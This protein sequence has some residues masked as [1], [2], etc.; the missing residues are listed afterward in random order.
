[1]KSSI[2]EG[3]LGAEARDPALEERYRAPLRGLT[4]RRLGPAARI[5]HAIGLVLGLG[6]SIRFIQL[7]VS[8]HAGGRPEQ[9]VGLGVGL[10]F[11]VCWALAEA[12]VLRAGV[13]R[14]FSHGAIRT[15][16]IVTFA[17]VLAGLMLWAGIQS[18]DPN[19]AMRLILFGLVFWCTIGLPFLMA[20][21][22]QSS[23]VRVRAS[24]LELELAR[25]EA[26]EE[27]S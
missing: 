9:W 6:L 8:L 23:E 10:S 4:E 19:R 13:E 15:A 25:A 2:K 1:V 22:V 21:L 20:H 17:F 24:L 11:S 3:L 26:Q 27:R 5:G 14:L 16:L 7:M 18:A 12:A